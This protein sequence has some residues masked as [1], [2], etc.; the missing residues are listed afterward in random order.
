VKVASATTIRKTIAR[1][2]TEFGCMCMGI[3]A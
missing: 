3:L 1:N 2:P